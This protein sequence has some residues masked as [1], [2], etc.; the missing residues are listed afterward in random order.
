[1]DVRRTS[2]TDRRTSWDVRFLRSNNGNQLGGQNQS[3]AIHNNRAQSVNYK[4]RGEGGGRSSLM[5]TPPDSNFDIHGKHTTRQSIVSDMN[6]GS[7]LKS[8]MSEVGQSRNTIKQKNPANDSRQLDRTNSATSAGEKLYKTTSFSNSGASYRPIAEDIEKYRAERTSSRSLKFSDP[9]L[10]QE[11]EKFFIFHINQTA[12]L[13][14]TNIVIITVIL[15]AHY[16]YYIVSGI[17]SNAVPTVVNNCPTG[18][19]CLDMQ[20]VNTKLTTQLKG[21][22]K[23]FNN[24]V[25]DFDSPL[26]KSVLILKSILADPAVNPNLLGLLDQVVQLLGSTNVLAPDLENQL[27]DFMDNEQEAYFF[28][29]IAPRKRIGGALRKTGAK[30]RRRSSIPMIQRK[31]TDTKSANPDANAP[32]Q[33]DSVQRE[34]TTHTATTTSGQ[35]TEN[36]KQ[37]L[38]VSFKIASQSQLMGGGSLSSGGAAAKPSRTPSNRLSKLTE[39]TLE[40]FN[41]IITSSTMAPIIAAVDTYNWKI[42]E[43]VDASENHPLCVLTGYFFERADLFGHFD[44]PHEKFWRFVATVE[45]AYH[46]NLP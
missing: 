34:L 2:I 26:E 1:M 44:I 10:E 22:Q 24:K 14:R 29:E 17:S 30:D 38:V 8:T 18:V 43:F 4:T 16:I 31:D 23:T 46:A 20:T 42:F 45:T 36:S 27:T 6:R 21:L 40:S 7:I 28:S 41:E 12:G 32:Q 37:N 13:W 5:A 15:V 25:A 11:Y 33:T 19:Y 39:M 35:S 3:S 9:A